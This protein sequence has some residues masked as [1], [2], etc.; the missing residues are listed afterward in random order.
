MKH[1]R[2]TQSVI[3]PN[4]RPKCGPFCK[5]VAMICLD[6]VRKPRP[7][8][9]GKTRI[10][11]DRFLRFLPYRISAKRKRVEKAQLRKSSLLWLERAKRIAGA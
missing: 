9:K 7:A 5:G 4:R 3:N 6:D 2:A 1:R 10:E 11:Y 8:A